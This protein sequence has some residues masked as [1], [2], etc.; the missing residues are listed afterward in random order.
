MYKVLTIDPGR[1]LGYA[2]WPSL[3]RSMDKPLIQPTAYGC[4]NMPVEGLWELRAK[5][6]FW[7]FVNLASDFEPKHVIVEN[8]ALWGGSTK[9]FTAG[10]KGS[11]F[12]LSHV[13]GLILA[14]AFILEADAHLVQPMIWK[15]TLPNR[16]VKQ[17]VLKAMG[18]QFDAVEHTFDALGLG[19]SIQG[20]LK[21][22]NKI[23]SLAE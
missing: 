8:Q 9:S 19:F 5:A 23:W 16:L 1:G 14:A 6:L 20:V 10:V 13:T 22:D 15:G 7:E 4:I 17:R 2:F 11:L 12:K 21:G 18:K 3:R